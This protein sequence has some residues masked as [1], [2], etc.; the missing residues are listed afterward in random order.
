MNIR[1]AI[2][3]DTDAIYALGE[4]VS[5]FSVNDETVNFWPKALL[6]S[7]VESDDVLVLIAEEQDI[8]GFV[9]VNYSFGLKKAIIENIYV[10]PKA[11][12]QGI[13]ARLLEELFTQLQAKGCEYIATLIPLDAHD[14]LKLY[15]G[16]GFSRG[17]SFVWLDKSLDDSFKK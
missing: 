13:G 6:S 7:A 9:I 11:R 2:A 12:G 14:A 16:K 15:T 10:D 8:M 1:K 4:H 5:E 17:E 3:G